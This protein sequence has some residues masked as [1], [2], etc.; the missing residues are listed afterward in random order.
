M[1]LIALAAGLMMSL[2]LQAQS[3]AIAQYFN[4]YM[5]DDR[6][7][8]VFV[9]PKMFDMVSKMDLHTDDP[10]AQATLDIIKDLEGLRIL[11]T[12]VTPR[13]FFQEAKAMLPGKGYEVLM[14]VRDNKSG[15]N[16]EFLVKE[17]GDR[18]HELL[19]L[20]GSSDE[21]VMLSFTGN[22]DLKKIGELSKVLNVEG[23][24]HL[25]KLEDQ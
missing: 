12:E 13:K 19:L 5:N 21:F 10:Q 14:T 25:E 1:R 24:E 3:D 22:I 16:V 2:G 20:V 17:A 6:F 11:T 8:V 7:T 4:K 9:S 15:D 23:A 18:I